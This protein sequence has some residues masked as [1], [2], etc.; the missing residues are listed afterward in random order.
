MKGNPHKA[1]FAVFRA[2][3]V[4]GIVVDSPPIIRISWLFCIE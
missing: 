3:Q 2:V 4:T 1:R